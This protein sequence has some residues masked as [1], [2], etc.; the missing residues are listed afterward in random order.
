M[1]GYEDRQED[2][3]SLLRFGF[4]RTHQSLVQK[5][6]SIR[7]F[8]PLPSDKKTGRDIIKLPSHEL[9]EQIKRDHNL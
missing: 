5:P 8:W 2:Q 9:M 7:E 3:A 4:F 1:A 6:L